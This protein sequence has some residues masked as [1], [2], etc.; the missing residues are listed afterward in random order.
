MMSNTKMR[1][2]IV[3]AVVAVVLLFG[4]IG[5]LSAQDT[6]AQDPSQEDSFL[7]LVER[8]TKCWRNM[9][10]LSSFRSRKRRRGACGQSTP[11]CLKKDA[12]WCATCTLA[13]RRG[14]GRCCRMFLRRPNRTERKTYGLSSAQLCL[15]RKLTPGSGPVQTGPSVARSRFGN[16]SF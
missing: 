10:R 3:F 15:S 1:R 2:N 11:I 9:L 8:M 16:R 5:A 7:E 12:G 6:A 4:R 14:S 13:R